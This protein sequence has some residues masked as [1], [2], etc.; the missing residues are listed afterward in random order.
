IVNGPL[1]GK[2]T[3]HYGISGDTAIIE[4]AQAAGLELVPLELRNPML[5]ST[6]GVGEMITDALN[7]G[8]RHIIICIGGSA[9]NDGGMGMLQALGAKI[10]DSDGNSL[11][12]R[13]SSLSQVAKIKLDDLDPRLQECTID[14]AC[15]VDNPLY[16][17]NGAAYVFAKQK[18][19]DHEMIE[20]LDSGLRNYGST[21]SDIAGQDISSMAG[22]G[23]AGGLGAALVAILHAR[24]KP[25][26][27]VVLDTIHFDSIIEGAQLIIT[28]EGHIDA[29]TLRGKAPI[30]VLRCGERAKI[31]VV[32]VAGQVDHM[33]ELHKAGIAAIYPISDPSLSLAENMNQATA[34]SHLE[35]TA[36]QIALQHLGSPTHS[37]KY[38]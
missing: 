27:D 37:Y 24:L 10:L 9:T 5:T 14:V 22:A 32:A 20:A 34:M 38:K 25:G 29:Q 21:L 16:G 15:D 26:I 36:V 4:M 13:G 12:G 8:C 3:A 30:G 7:H 28:G 11:P 17:P 23:A 18:G 19:A 35:T 6:F 1:S 2:V 33:Q 31:P